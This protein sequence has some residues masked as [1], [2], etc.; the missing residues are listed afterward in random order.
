VKARKNVPS[1]DG[2]MTRCPSTEEVAPERSMSAWSM[3]LPPA[4]MACT[5]VSTLRPGS[6]AADTS[7]EANGGV[8]EALRDPRRTTRVADQQQAGIGHQIGLVEGHAQ[9][10]RSCAIL[11]SQKVPPGAG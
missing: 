7:R 5:K 6:R 2:A 10:G 8:D 1:V 4:T 3:W 11:T 9:S